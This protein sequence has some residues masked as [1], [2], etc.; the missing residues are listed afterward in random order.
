M[1]APSKPTT[2]DAAA[3]AFIK[4]EADTR[5][6]LSRLRELLGIKPDAKTGGQEGMEGRT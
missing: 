5:E 2:T 4:S 6:A 1:T 3:D